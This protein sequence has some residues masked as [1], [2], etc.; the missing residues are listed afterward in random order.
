MKILSEQEMA[1]TLNFARPLRPEPDPPQS[2]WCVPFEWGGNVKGTKISISKAK[3]IAA[4]LRA[5]VAEAE[6]RELRR[7]FDQEAARAND[8]S[9][10][11]ADKERELAE[12]NAT[13]EVLERRLRAAAR[14]RRKR[15]R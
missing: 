8:L 12:A 7:H 5:L 1:E 9:R 6:G 14:K 4:E 11:L 13:I 3:E 10:R 15:S 2:I